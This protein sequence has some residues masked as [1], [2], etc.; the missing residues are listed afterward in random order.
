MT[1]FSLLPKADQ[2][3]FAIGV[4]AR[5]LRQCYMPSRRKFADPRDIASQMTA[6]A[7]A[8][9]ELPPEWVQ[10]LMTIKLNND[11]DSRAKPRRRGPVKQMSRDF[12]VTGA[13]QKIIA[14]Y[15]FPATRN[16]GTRDSESACSIV[17]RALERIGVHLSEE[18]VEKIWEKWPRGE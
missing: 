12:W 13:I 7:F 6:D 11:L 10:T 8:R 14:I 3:A 4:T 9:G 15:R 16:R 17:A 18:G 1:E 2:I 5:F